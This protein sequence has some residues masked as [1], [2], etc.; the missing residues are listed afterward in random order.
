MAFVQLQLIVEGARLRCPRRRGA[1]RPLAAG[2]GA[3]NVLAPAKHIF[4]DEG[5][6]SF[7]LPGL[8]GSFAAAPGTPGWAVTFI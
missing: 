2:R 7:W 8:F 1:S 4:A 6:V 3:T 5:G